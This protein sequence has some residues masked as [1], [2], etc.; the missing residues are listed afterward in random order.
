[1]K[2]FCRDITST[3]SQRAAKGAIVKKIIPNKAGKQTESL[4]VFDADYLSAFVLSV[5]KHFI[6]INK[7]HDVRMNGDF[8]TT[9]EKL[10]L[11]NIP[12]ASLDSLKNIHQLDYATSGVLCVGRTREAA[13]IGSLAFASRETQKEYIAVVEGTL[14]LDR[15][16]LKEYNAQYSNEE[17]KFLEKDHSMRKRQHSM[18]ASDNVND[19]CKPSWQLEIMQTSLKICLTELGIL[20]CN[21]LHQKNSELNYLAS[22]KESDFQ[23]DHRLRKR[24]RKALKCCGVLLEDKMPESKQS[25]STC[26]QNESTK[27]QCVSSECSEISMNDKVESE[28]KEMV[29]IFKYNHASGHRLVVRVPVA[30]IEGDFRMELGHT[31]N[32]GKFSET[33][34]EIMEHA[35]YQVFKYFSIYCT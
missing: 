19:E 14:C 6:V 17:S 8:D 15:W 9:V 30:N 1:M 18:M 25:V 29:R 28:V 10:L 22:V 3:V 11:K 7:P 26:V 2:T 21:E 35:I 32:P 4:S 16:P 34:V 31:N 20:L 13:A 24:L 23:R 27:L 5:T 33:V 12:G